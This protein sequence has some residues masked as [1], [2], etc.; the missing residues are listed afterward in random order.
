MYA[1]L[2]IRQSI[3]GPNRSNV[4]REFSHA[5]EQPT[6]EQVAPAIDPPNQ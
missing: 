5:A 6:Q 3:A 1:G 2:G 4:P